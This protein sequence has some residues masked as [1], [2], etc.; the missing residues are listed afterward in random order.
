MRW[1]GIALIAGLAVVVAVCATALQAGSTARQK[2]G[3]PAFVQWSVD[4]D[5]KGDPE[6]AP[7]GA[8][9]FHAGWTTGR[10]VLVW[11]KNGH[12]NSGAN[13]SPPD[14]NDFRVVWARA[15]K[16]FTKA[17]W[18]KDG[19]DVARIPIAA[20]S[21]DLYAALENSVFDRAFWSDRNGGVL[22]PIQ[23]FPGAN[24]VRLELKTARGHH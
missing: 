15:A 12:V 23:P 6:G 1:K 11:T 18:T 2:A 21:N 10:A 3:S 19:A 24:D 17:F 9:D 13:V 22:R 8:R 14:A 16:V 7:A 4:G 5:L 20:G